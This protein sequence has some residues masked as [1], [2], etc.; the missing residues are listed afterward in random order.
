MKSN[1]ISSILAG[2]AIA[3]A[4][5]ATNAAVQITNGDFNAGSET[6]NDGDVADPWYDANPANFWEAVWHINHDQPIMSDFPSPMAIFSA[7]SAPGNN[8]LYQNI[9]TRGAGDTSLPLAFE[10]GSF[11]DTADVRSGTLTVS[12]Y[13]SGSFVGANDVDVAASGATLI[14][15]AVVMTGDLNP[16]G[17]IHSG[18]TLDLGSANLTDSLFLHFSMNDAWIGLDNIQVVPEPSTFALIGMGLAFLAV[19]RRRS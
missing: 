17:A 15:S 3:V 8:Y 14:D 19:R 11:T 12:I 7:L 16:G 1:L 13:Q 10:L 2:I 6:P 9:G 5:P 4:A 18:V